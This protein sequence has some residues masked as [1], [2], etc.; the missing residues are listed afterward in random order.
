[1]ANNNQIVGNS[2]LYYVSYK[3]S[4]IGWNVATTAR[5]ARGIDIIVYSRSGKQKYTI[6]VKSLSKRDTVPLGNT[7]ENL[8]MADFFIICNK[9]NKEPDIFI[10]KPSD[11]IKKAHHGYSEDGKRTESYWLQANEY[12]Q[13]GKDLSII[14]NPN[15]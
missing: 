8:S 10:T 2:G 12:E 13:F 15:Q 9:L 1:M 7:L 3:L 6:Q 4:K 14:G 5:N 11:V